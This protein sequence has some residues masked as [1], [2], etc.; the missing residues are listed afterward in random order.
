M[1]KSRKP[2]KPSDFLINEIFIPR[3]IDI[4]D[5]CKI[6]DIDE[7]E[8]SEFLNNSTKITQEIADKLS[9]A[10]GTSSSVWINLQKNF[11]A[12]ENQ[13]SPAQQIKNILIQR[14]EKISVAE[15]LTSGL[16]QS[17][18]AEISGI[19]ACFEGGI[20]SYSLTSKVNHLDV[21]PTMAISV[22]CVHYEIALQM[23]DGVRKMFD[24]ELSIA[25]TGYAE[26]YPAEN[27][28]VPI[29]YIGIH[30][31]GKHIFYEVKLEDY[32]DHANVREYMRN[33]VA[34]KALEYALNFISE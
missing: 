8:L 22:N 10:F 3:K 29:A 26:A 5:A 31:H 13:E 12:W 15:S 18:L 28:E 24:T 4:E 25:T 21:D 30:Y 33:L 19:S 1:Y 11:E 14:N 16:L 9:K 27:I 34:D 23:S 17:K 6:I 32:Q 2:T 7:L 20:T